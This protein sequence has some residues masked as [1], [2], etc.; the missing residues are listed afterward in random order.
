MPNKKERRSVI[1]HHHLFK[2]A[3][4][5]LDATLK[6]NFGDAWAT[7]E[8]KGSDDAGLAEWI[9]DTPKVA[10]FSSHTA[11]IVPLRL[12]DTVVTQCVLMR[13]PI[14][15]IQSAYVFE[16]KQD[17]ET[18][19]AIFARSH[20]FP[21]Y[22]EYRLGKRRDSQCRNFHSTRLAAFT[23]KISPKAPPVRRALA[24]L[25]LLPFVG[26]VEEYDESMR[27]LGEL[28][29]VTFPDFQATMVRANAK[30]DAGRSL[31]AKLAGIKEE[32]GHS[33]YRKLTLAN[34][35][36]LVVYQAARRRFVED[37]LNG[38]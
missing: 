17:A 34:E 23:A 21:E 25:H 27:R 6:H 12:P 19:G 20:S 31:P 22:V 33:L 11:P 5:S 3:G 14:D 13:H 10:A 37:G 4:T 24:A 36:D 26:I 15:R 30:R 28:V 7:R 1:V 29:R 18:D 38:H 32:L 35:D 8:F 16:S 2:N 9:N